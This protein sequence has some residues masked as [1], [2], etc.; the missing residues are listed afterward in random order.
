MRHVGDQGVD[1]EQAVN[2][3]TDPKVNW[4]YLSDGVYAAW[5]TLAP[6]LI[7]LVTERNGKWHEIAL[8]PTAMEVLG[9]MDT[10]RFV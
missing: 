2:P 8:D 3:S 5:D 1:G 9:K 7:W 10:E 4:R 6:E